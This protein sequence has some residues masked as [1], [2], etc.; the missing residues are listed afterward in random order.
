MKIAR[1][2]LSLCCVLLITSA[3]C[4]ETVRLT[5]DNL[6]DRVWIPVDFGTT[7]SGI[8]DVQARITGYSADREF[9]CTDSQ[10]TWYESWWAEVEFSQ[11]RL[12]KFQL[13]DQSAFELN[14]SIPLPDG[15]DW[16][17]LQDGR[18]DLRFSSYNV[19]GSIGPLCYGSPQGPFPEY[20]VLILEVTCETAVAN[21]TGTW[22]SIKAFH[23]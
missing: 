16:S 3:A 15:T 13:P 11:E 8:T 6:P 17:D 20:Y 18:I 4:A 5:I 1:I 19:T 10:L 12:V 14:A 9:L 21:E 23:R 2:L 7:M 22:G